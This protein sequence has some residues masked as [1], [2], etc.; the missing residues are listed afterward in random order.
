MLIPITWYLYVSLV[1]LLCGR[2]SYGDA[3]E[4][5][6]VEDGF[7]KASHVPDGGSSVGCMGAG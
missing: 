6:D 1:M 3:E 5:C 2:G 4:Q 7:D